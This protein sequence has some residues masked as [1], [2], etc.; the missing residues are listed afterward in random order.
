MHNLPT[1][2]ET[3][4]IRGIFAR[5]TEINNQLAEAVV[6]APQTPDANLRLGNPPQ[7]PAPG[8]LRVQNII[9][10]AMNP[11][12]IVPE[13]Q[14]MDTAVNSF[15]A[16]QRIQ[17]T[18]NNALYPSVEAPL[19]TGTPSTRTPIAPGSSKQVMSAATQTA[20]D[21]IMNTIQGIINTPNTANN[22]SAPAKLPE[23]PMDSSVRQFRNREEE[24]KGTQP[25][26]EPTKGAY[27]SGQQVPE[28]E[29]KARQAKAQAAWEAKK[30]Q[31]AASAKESQGLQTT[32][33]AQQARLAE[34]DKSNT[35]K[36]AA[37][38]AQAAASKKAA[39]Q[40]DPEAAAAKRMI[41][42]AAGRPEGEDLPAGMEQRLKTA[43]VTGGMTSEPITDFSREAE[44]KRIA[45][46]DQQRLGLN[47]KKDLYNVR[48]TGYGT[49]VSRLGVQ[50]SY[51][52]RLANLFEETRDSLEDVS[53]KRRERQV[54]VAGLEGQVN[55]H[56]FVDLVKGI[57]NVQAFSGMGGGG[58]PKER[59]EKKEKKIGEKTVGRADQ[60]EALMKIMSASQNDPDF[61]DKFTKEDALNPDSLLH[62]ALVS[63]NP[64]LQD[65]SKV[66][67]KYYT[68]S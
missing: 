8:S 3:N 57:R 24:Q 35:A 12:G 61:K 31:A 22:P 11:Q 36:I 64:S 25:L 9:N 47:Y 46:R 50:E 48:D 17:G 63:R 59:V 54:K 39:E 27:E 30:A 51:Y 32:I 68:G 53:A 10:T 37:L 28:S 45:A 40:A 33:N 34:L 52:H 43:P 67:A 5:T 56:G 60:R 4:L 44:R 49:S 62:K 66:M 14:P 7:I 23:Q 29:W 18:I 58:M 19:P 21:N 16:G 41:N 6:L 55:P 15:K 13:E 65:E 1:N 2:N 26:P 38:Q 20:V 42:R